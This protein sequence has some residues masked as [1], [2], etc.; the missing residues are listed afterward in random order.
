M[1]LA[2]RLKQL[3]AR[4]KGEVTLSAIRVRHVLSMISVQ[5]IT[6]CWLAFVPD[7]A[8]PTPKTKAC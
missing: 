4:S 2:P 7:W 6:P 8:V 1:A 3:A 5:T